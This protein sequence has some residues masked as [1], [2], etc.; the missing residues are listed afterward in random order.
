MGIS[1][2][3]HA[4]QYPNT[5]Q[6]YPMLSGAAYP[7]YL[8][9]KGW[10][11]FGRKK[12]KRDQALINHWYA[13]PALWQYPAQYTCEYILPRT[14]CDA[15]GRTCFGALLMPFKDS[16]PTSDNCLHTSR[17]TCRLPY[18]LNLSRNSQLMEEWKSD[19]LSSFIS[20]CPA[21]PFLPIS[22]V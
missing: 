15:Y 9:S 18:V 17:S 21:D 2:S 16:M 12:K 20:A 4:S 14:C 7:P 19:A 1:P 6:G 13:T 8:P 11:W 3:K 5:P 22:N 10:S